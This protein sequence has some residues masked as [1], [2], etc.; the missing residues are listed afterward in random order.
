MVIDF[1]TN[2]GYHSG[3]YHV[4]DIL[5]CPDET[6]P[7]YVQYLGVDDQGFGIWLKLDARQQE[8]DSSATTDRADAFSTRHRIESTVLYSAQSRFTVRTGG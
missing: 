3:G 6:G 5:I 7:L 1:R 4:G 8:Q 2:G